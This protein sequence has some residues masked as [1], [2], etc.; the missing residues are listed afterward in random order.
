MASQPGQAIECLTDGIEPRQRNLVAMKTVNA[1]QA[2]HQ[3]SGLLSR[4]EEILITRRNNGRDLGALSATADDAGVQKDHAIE[5]MKEGLAWGINYRGLGAMLCMIAHDHLGSIGSSANATSGERVCLAPQSICSPEWLNADLCPPCCFVAISMN[6]AVMPAAQRDRELITHPASEGSALRK[7]EVVRIGRLP[8]ANQTGMSCDEFHM[9]SI[10]DSTWLRMGRTAFFDLLDSGSSG[11]LESFSL[12]RCFVVANRSK[13]RW[14]WRCIARPK[15]SS[16][17][18][19]WNA[20]SNCRAS[21]M[22]NKFLAGRM[23]R[24]QTAAAATELTS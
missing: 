14:R 7:S 11:R 20:F 17:N 5:V 12:N 16:A 2:N 23:R 19:A 8:T 3:F 18:L 6:F 15:F 24:A 9:L 10:A 13:G 21:A 22:F 1:R 4:G